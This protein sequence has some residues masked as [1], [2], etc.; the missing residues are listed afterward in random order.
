MKL[1]KK[2]ESKEKAHKSKAEGK[3][4]VKNP[5]FGAIAPSESCND[6][7]CPFH[8]DLKIRGRTFTGTVTKSRS[9]KTATVSWE[10]MYYIPKYERYE[11]RRTKIQVHNPPCINAEEGDIVNITECRPLSKTKHFVIIKKMGKK[12]AVRGEDVTLVEVDKKDHKKEEPK[13]EGKE[14]K[15]E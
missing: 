10:R 14:K 6:T 8:G 2:T 15:K 3:G 5:G 13:K 9:Q 12:E 7:K 11:K 4:S 1:D